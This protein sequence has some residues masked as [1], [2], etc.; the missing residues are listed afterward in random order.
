MDLSSRPRAHCTLA[1]VVTVRL[2]PD[3]TESE[4]GSLCSVVLFFTSLFEPTGSL[5]RRATAYTRLHRLGDT[6]PRHVPPLINAA[7]ISSSPA[8]VGIEIRDSAKLMLTF[9]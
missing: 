4:P 1:R 5:S 9:D 2:S 8:L 6:F 3:E 7:R